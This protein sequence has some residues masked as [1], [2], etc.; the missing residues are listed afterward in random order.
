M[1]RREHLKVWPSDP[2]VGR[3]AGWEPGEE[4]RDGKEGRLL[5]LDFTG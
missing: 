3:F 1:F 2:L 5:D 4:E